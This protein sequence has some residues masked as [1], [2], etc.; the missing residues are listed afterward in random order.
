MQQSLWHEDIYE[1]LRAL[2]EVLEDDQG[3]R[4]IKA[5]ACW[6]YGASRSPSSAHRYL[7]HALDAERS[8]VLKP[9]EVMTLLRRGCEQGAHVAK[10]F[11]DDETGYERARPISIDDQRDELQREF[12]RSARLQEQLVRRLEAL[13]GDAR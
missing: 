7:L 3:R 4:G 2:C 6:L 1:A 8:E 12:I 11:M 10:H 13:N 5:T 9:H